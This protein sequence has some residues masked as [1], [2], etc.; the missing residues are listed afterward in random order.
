M[1][2]S[3]STAIPG[4]TMAVTVALGSRRIRCLLELDL[5]LGSSTLIFINSWFKRAQC[6][7]TKRSKLKR[8]HQNLP[9]T[10]FTTIPVACRAPELETLDGILQSVSL[11]KGRFG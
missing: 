6:T 8:M 1:K 5:L 4:L 7:V 2:P 11:P 10:D 3:L 9:F